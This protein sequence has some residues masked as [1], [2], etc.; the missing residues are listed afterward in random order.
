M[1]KRTTIGELREVINGKNKKIAE[2]EGEIIRMQEAQKKQEEAVA[3]T[4]TKLG[5]TIFKLES[6]NRQLEEQVDTLIK[7]VGKQYA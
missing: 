6:R 7:A 5:Q 3:E 4:G 1:K 2:L